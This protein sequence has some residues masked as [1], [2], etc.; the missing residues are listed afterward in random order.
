MNGDSKKYFE[1]DGGTPKQAYIVVAVLALVVVAAFSA[2][3]V[4]MGGDADPKTTNAGVGEPG[5][6]NYT[7]LYEDSKHGVVGVMTVSEGG[8]GSGT[9]FIYDSEGYIVT[10]AHVVEGAEKVEV[11]YSNGEWVEA[12]V[13]GA[14][15]DSDLAVLSPANESASAEVLEMVEENPERG[16]R[17]MVLGSPLDLDESV[18]H[19]IVSGTDRELRRSNGFVI[20]DVIQTDAPVNPGNSGSPV[21]NSDGEV[22]GVVSAR[23]GDNIGFAISPELTN[24]IVPELI[25]NGSVNH[26]YVGIRTIQNDP[27]VAD[28]NNYSVNHGMVVAEV[29]EGTPADGVLQGPSETGSVTSD[30]GVRVPRGGD[31]IVGI[32]EHEVRTGQQFSAYLMKETSPGDTVTVTV[33]RGGEEVDVEVTLGDRPE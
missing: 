3:A 9:G 2:G 4:L 10:N 18:S 33:F 21:V 20:P 16:E 19:G 6:I 7:E 30:S 8:S 15:A 13:V 11:Q 26:S 28:A 1:P 32:D 12:E 5:G 17:V 14:D 22:I 24:A 27:V 31:V 23:Q 29:V 25:A